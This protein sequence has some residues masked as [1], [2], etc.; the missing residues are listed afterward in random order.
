VNIMI[1]KSLL[2]VTAL[3]ETST[4]LA[5]LLSPPLVAGLLLGASPDE[6]V[7]LVV[8][9]VAGAALLSL[10]IGCWL[11]RDDGS[12]RAGRGLVAAMLFYN[13][14]TVAVLA[15]AAAGAGLAGALLWPTVVLHALLAAWCIACLRAGPV[16]AARPR[17]IEPVN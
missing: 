15:Y 11:A 5:L 16:H 9:R 8:S 12:S 10:G 1:P 2:T 4:G 7:S 13:S 17:G 3:I 14:A 6:P